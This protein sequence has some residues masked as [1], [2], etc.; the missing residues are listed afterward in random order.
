MI[1]RQLGSGNPLIPGGRQ[2]FVS[3]RP[4]QCTESVPGL[5]RET[6]CQ[7]RKEGREGETEE[8]EGKEREDLACFVRILVKLYFLLER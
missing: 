2:V 7:N 4:A 3:S 6:L 5:Q 8:R 1:K